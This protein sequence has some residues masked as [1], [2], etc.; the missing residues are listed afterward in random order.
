[1]GKARYTPGPWKIGGKSAIYSAD[2]RLLAFSIYHNREANLRLIAAAPDL[3]EAL[4]SFPMLMVPTNNGRELSFQDWRA[5]I[6]S[7]E[8]W[9]E[10]ALAALAKAEGFNPDEVGR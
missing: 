8:E 9:R 7:V 6:R 1:M 5:W 2:E 10:S 3:L 4:K